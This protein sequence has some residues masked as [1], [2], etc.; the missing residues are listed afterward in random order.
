ML[1]P[2]SPPFLATSQKVA[3]TSKTGT[4]MMMAFRMCV[5]LG[6]LHWALGRGAHRRRTGASAGA[7]PGCVSGNGVGGE[8]GLRPATGA[9]EAAPKGGREMVNGNILY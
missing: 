4:A 5:L 6:S 7:K 3:A 9:H 2:L 1:A 8:N